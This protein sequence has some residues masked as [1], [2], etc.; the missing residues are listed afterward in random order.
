ML[1]ATH[2]F[3]KCVLFAIGD[4]I[5]DKEKANSARRTLD[6]TQP[7]SAALYAPDLRL[8]GHAVEQ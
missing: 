1:V 7:T 3:S 5:V 6:E 4:P 8:L 2:P